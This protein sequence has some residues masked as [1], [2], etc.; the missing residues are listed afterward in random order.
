MKEFIKDKLRVKVAENRF[1]MGEIAMKDF[2]RK[3]AELLTS[4]EEINVIF[5]AA[6]SQNDVL[7]CLCK[8]KSISWDRINAYHMDEYAG[9][10]VNDPR[11]FGYFLKE[12]IFGKVNFKSVTYIGSGKSER[13]ECER[14]ARL[15]EANPPD[16]VLMGIG[17]NGHIA[18]NDPGVADFRDKAIIKKVEL[19]ETCRLQQ[20]HD[21]C[22]SSL[23]EVPRFAFT[24]T[25]PV[26]MRAKALFCVVPCRTK[27]RAVKEMLGGAISEKCPATILRTHDFATLYIEPES[28]SLLAL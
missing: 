18:F 22:F 1:R 10:T 9:L 17:E 13:E 5:A 24:L 11:S 7:A 25:V 23:E 4:Q 19:E 8:S 26:L 27:A 15:I 16:I 2:E 6:P 12:H 20:V 3:V 28:A 14:Y 21:G